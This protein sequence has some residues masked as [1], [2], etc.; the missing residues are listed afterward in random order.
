MFGEIFGTPHHRLPPG[1]RPP[2]PPPPP[3]PVPHPSSYVIV[4]GV[5]FY[6]GHGFIDLDQVL[7]FD[8]ARTVRFKNGETVE[9]PEALAAALRDHC[10]FMHR[11]IH[12]L[13]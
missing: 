10:A 13:D 5:G 3:K 12:P 4:G 8:D 1:L 6:A 2:P 11:Q 7:C 9:L